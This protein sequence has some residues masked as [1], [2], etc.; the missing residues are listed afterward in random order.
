MF[1][2]IIGDK[3]SYRTEI[4]GSLRE[5]AIYSGGLLVRGYIKREETKGG[6]RLLVKKT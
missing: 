6:K 4:S 2:G 3:N 5:D 1:F